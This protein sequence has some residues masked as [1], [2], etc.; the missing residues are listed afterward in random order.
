MLDRQY[1]DLDSKR[2][3]YHLLPGLD[4]HKPTLVL[5]HEG[6]GCVDLWKDFPAALA[7][8]TGIT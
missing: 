8:A 7:N 5:L 6:L 2:L 3:E 4:R 1:L